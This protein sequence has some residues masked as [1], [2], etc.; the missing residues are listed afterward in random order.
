MRA[1]T[2]AYGTTDL[3]PA[4]AIARSEIR[5]KPD[6]PALGDDE[7]NRRGTQWETPDKGNAFLR[8]RE[9]HFWAILVPIG[10]YYVIS[11]TD[12]RE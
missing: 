7:K 1:C 6:L 5:R 4:H 12:G 10:S 9:T 3:G 8:F 11:D 2:D